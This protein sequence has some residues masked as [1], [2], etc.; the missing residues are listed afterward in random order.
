MGRETTPS[1]LAG[2]AAAIMIALA[3]LGGGAAAGAEV[4]QK[5]KEKVLDKPL[6]VQ[7]TLD[8]NKQIL[9]GSLLAYD[10]QKFVMSVNGKKYLVR[11]SDL[12][13]G[14]QYAV[15]TQLIDKKNPA[16]WLELAD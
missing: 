12:A 4:K 1:C 6:N 9:G 3:V 11:W 14:S 15:R 13:P 16:D 8:A 7:V 2:F 10:A 5:D